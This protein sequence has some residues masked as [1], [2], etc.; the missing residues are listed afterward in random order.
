M[1]T[2]VFINLP[3]KDLAASMDFF[4]RLGFSFNEQFT[5]ENAACLVLSDTV[6]VMLL[7]EEFFQTFTK[8]EIVD[9]TKMTE[10]LTAL[11]V[12]SREAVDE[13]LAK[14]LEAGAEEG[15]EAQDQGF[16]YSRSFEDPDGHV[17]EIFFMDESTIAESTP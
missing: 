17:W 11:S 14:A 13:L 10:V 8:K 5:N 9:A 2:K 1:T 16:M 7:V 15:R 4:G 12:E 3:V 6:F